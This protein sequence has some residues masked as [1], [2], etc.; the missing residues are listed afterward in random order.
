[1]GV[2]DLEDYMANENEGTQ[3]L[4]EF[5]QQ[6]RRRAIYGLLTQARGIWG[7]EHMGLP[8][9]T[10]RLMVGLGDIA[11]L[12]RGATKDMQIPVD[13][14]EL[15]KELGN[16]IFSTIRFADDL[17]LDPMDCLNQA[18]EAQEKFARENPQR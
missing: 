5:L 13:R 17:G 1:M 4:E 2:F 12:A 15:E 9:I 11:R 14:R 7:T 10:V 6:E 3:D 16:L 8:A 18:I